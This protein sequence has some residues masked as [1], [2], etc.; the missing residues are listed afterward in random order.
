MKRLI[1]LILAAAL[2]L[3][4]AACGGSGNSGNSEENSN[5]ENDVNTSIT[6]EDDATKYSL[7]ETVST[8]IIDFTLDDCQ[9]AIYANAT[10]GASFLKPTEDNTVYGASIGHTLIIPSF[11]LT[12]KDRSGNVDVGGSTFGDL[13]LMWTML[14]N[15]QEYN[16]LCFDLNNN[17]SFG[18]KLSPAAIIDSESGD[19][20][21]QNQSNNYLLYAGET[22]SFRTLGIVSVETETLNDAFELTINLP[23]SSGEYEYFTYSISER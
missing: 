2:A 10:T 17:N 22:I 18:M 7:G 15:N 1:A 6:N 4:L 14:Y 12:N 9:L 5:S 3:S 8:D 19:M 13:T 21:S 20:I 23:N 16:V 11:T